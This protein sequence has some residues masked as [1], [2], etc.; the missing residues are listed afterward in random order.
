[1]KYSCYQVCYSWLV[2]SLAFCLRDASLV[3]VGNPIS[4]GIVFVFHLA[5]MRIKRI[6]NSQ[7]TLALLDSFYEPHLER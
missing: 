1:M 6:Q 4:D 2:C 5:L 7:A 3:K